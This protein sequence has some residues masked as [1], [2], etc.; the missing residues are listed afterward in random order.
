MADLRECREVGDKGAGTWEGLQEGGG[1]L[2]SVVD[3]ETSGV[4]VFG[5]S[6]R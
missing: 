4:V 2:G 3:P 5:G 6:G 1:T